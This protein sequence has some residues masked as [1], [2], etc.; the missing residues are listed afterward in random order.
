MVVVGSRNSDEVHIQPRDLGEKHQKKSHRRHTVADSEVDV[1]VMKGS[2][3]QIGGGEV[4]SELKLPFV[5]NFYE[6]PH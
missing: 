2:A 6:V 5:S 1:S 4:V 3:L